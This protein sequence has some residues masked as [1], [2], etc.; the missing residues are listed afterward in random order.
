MLRKDESQERRRTYTYV[1]HHGMNSV[2]VL[3]SGAEDGDGV[4]GEGGEAG[5]SDELGIELPKVLDDVE[6]DADVATLTKLFAK[7]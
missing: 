3:E 4:F 5:G 6:A 1:L 7:L 2:S